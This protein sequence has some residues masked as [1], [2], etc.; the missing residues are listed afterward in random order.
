MTAP[1]AGSLDTLLSGA[2][3]GLRRLDPAAAARAQVAGA[4]LVDIRPH[5]F[6][7]AEGE[8]PGALVVERNV[9]EWRFAPD[10]PWRL[11]EAGHVDVLVLVCNEGYASSLAAD[12]LRRLGLTGATDLAGGFRAWAAAGLP[13]LPGGSPALP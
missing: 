10:S 1:A 12:A 2:R 7:A 4:V 13:V 9:L 6:R 5:A 3:S 8:I 11:P